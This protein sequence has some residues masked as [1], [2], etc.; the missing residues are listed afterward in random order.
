M[1]STLSEGQKLIQKP[2]RSPF[3]ERSENDKVSYKYFG[4]EES[5][6][7]FCHT[8]EHRS[9]TGGPRSGS[10]PKSRPTRTRTYSQNIR[11]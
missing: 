6:Q 5:I 8:L 3:K 1:S 9:L 4:F 2:L 7:L 10:G 11:L